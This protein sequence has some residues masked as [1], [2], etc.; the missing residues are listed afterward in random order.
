L[1][2]H[3]LLLPN[4]GI[5]KIWKRIQ[6]DLVADLSAHGETTWNSFFKPNKEMTV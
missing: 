1:N 4:G 5:A 6:I 2:Q 3:H